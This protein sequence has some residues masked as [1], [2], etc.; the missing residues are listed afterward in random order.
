[1]DFRYLINTFRERG[2]GRRGCESILELTAVG[3]LGE[4]QR[5][6]RE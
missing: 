2:Q 6:F 4:K 1:M 5:K 3:D